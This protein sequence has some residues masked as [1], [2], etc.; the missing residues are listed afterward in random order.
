[1]VIGYIQNPTGK[2]ATMNPYEFTVTYPSGIQMP[3][4]ISYD[5]QSVS[6]TATMNGDMQLTVKTGVI[7]YHTLFVTAKTQNNKTAA[8]VWIVARDAQGVAKGEGP[9]NA[10]GIWSV[11]LIGQRIDT[12]GNV[13]ETMNPYNI[14]AA[15]DSGQI[16]ASADM[17]ASDV[18]LDIKEYV[19]PTF[20]LS[21][22]AAVAAAA[23]VVFGAA[24]FVVSRK[25]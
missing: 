8:G 14:T 10:T 17:S 24:L 7:V 18:A 13:D 22:A 25:P 20:D 1:L 19:P 5:P 15:F 3:A 9:T 12:S 16:L 21:I 11:L 23:A 4:K 6:G 2:D